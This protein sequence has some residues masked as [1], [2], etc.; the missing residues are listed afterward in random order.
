MYK[1]ILKLGLGL[2][3]LAGFITLIVLYGGVWS[4]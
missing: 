2:L 1:E 4:G 3:V